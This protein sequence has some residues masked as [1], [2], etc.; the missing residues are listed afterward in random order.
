MA[1]EIKQLSDDL[2]HVN[3]KSIFK[4][5]EGNWCTQQELTS[6]EGEAFIDFKK[7]IENPKEK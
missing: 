1:V 6:A 4:D 3:G 2:I 7:T 5:M